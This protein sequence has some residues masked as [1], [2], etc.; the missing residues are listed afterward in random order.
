MEHSDGERPARAKAWAS[1]ALTKR[2]LDVALG[3]VGLLTV[4]P[5]VA[6]AAVAVAIDD[7]T[8]VLFRQERVGRHNK[9]FTLLKVRTMRDGRATRVGGWLRS[10]GLDELP[11]LLNVLRGDMSLVGPRPL[12]SHDVHRLGWDR[13]RFGLRFRMPPGLTGPVQ[14]LGAVSA[15]DSAALERA[16]V[17]RGGVDT[18]LAILGATAVMLA[19]GRDR[20]QRL[21]RRALR[22]QV[23][24]WT[25]DLGDEHSQEAS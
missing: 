16:Y 18:D 17:C 4:A 8:P 14:V 12:T 21:L 7:G 9:P 5:V 13:P 6:A 22:S 20:V 25:S 15:T 11:Q 3:S 19:A 24:A 1:P 2:A 10:S 23:E